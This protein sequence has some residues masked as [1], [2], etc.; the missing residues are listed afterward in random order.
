MGSI[1]AEDLTY[2][3]QDSVVGHRFKILKE[4]DAEVIK[5]VVED[6]RY[7]IDNYK[8]VIATL[9]RGM[10]SKNDVYKKANM[11]RM[12]G[13]E[14]ELEFGFNYDIAIIISNDGV[15]SFHRGET[16]VEDLQYTAWREVRHPENNEDFSKC[17]TGII[18]IIN[19]KGF[20]EQVKQKMFEATKDVP[21]LRM[22]IYEA[23]GKRYW[24]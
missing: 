17:F 2:F 8:E 15:Y 10:A 18:C 1:I 21:E 3:I 12:F 23:S 5:K 22:P 14:Y 20:Y 11:N 13:Y 16:Q 4:D 6:P 7:M 24:P 9:V 19:N